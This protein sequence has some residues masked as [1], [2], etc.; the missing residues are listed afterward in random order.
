M[1]PTITLTIPIL[2]S[3]LVINSNS[4]QIYSYCQGTLQVVSQHGAVTGS[5]GSARPSF[6]RDS[7]SL[8]EMCQK[9]MLYRDDE[10][11]PSHT[12]EYNVEVKLVLELFFVLVWNLQRLLM[13]V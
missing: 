7:R 6:K 11:L 8:I 4:T 10:L 13:M 1:R 12:D 2:A 9:N 3:L 5:F